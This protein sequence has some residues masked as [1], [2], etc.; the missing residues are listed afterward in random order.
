LFIVNHSGEVELE[1]K[2]DLEK[3]KLNVAIINSVI[4]CF[5]VFTQKPK[6]LIEIEIEIPVAKS[7]S[8]ACE[9]EILESIPNMAAVDM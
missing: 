3:N 6:T 9:Y 2:F 4:F 8:V 1:R 7:I 5:F